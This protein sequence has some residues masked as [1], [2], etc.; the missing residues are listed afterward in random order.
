[1]TRRKAT[2]STG[3]TNGQPTEDFPSG[4]KA[5]T[6]EEQ[7]EKVGAS[8]T[9][10]E[11]TPRPQTEPRPSPAAI[12][13]FDPATYRLQPSLLVAEGVQKHL[14]ELPVRKPDKS[15]WVRVHPDPEY[16]LDTF[17]IELKE[18]QETYLVLPPLWQELHG[19]STFIALT[20]HLAVTRQGKLFLWPVRRP[21]DPTQ[22]PTRWM[23]PTLQAI[24]HAVNKWTRIEWNL[25]TRQHDVKTC[26]YTAD[27]QWPELPFRDLLKIAFRDYVISTRDHPV[28][29][30]LRGE[31]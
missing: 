1:M 30:R 21:T 25:E 27:P 17:V 18:E 11:S 2:V 16:A 12:D 3:P 26:K 5:P 9:P 31:E 24:G 10:T 6:T 19:E 8:T 15:W 4:A 20:L 7:T 14:T 28:L 22:E 13:P 23:R 29:R